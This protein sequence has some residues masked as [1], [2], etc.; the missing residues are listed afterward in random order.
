MHIDFVPKLARDGGPGMT[1]ITDGQ[2]LRAILA[3]CAGNLIEWY[4]FYVYAFTS[5]YFA[6]AFF[7]A[8][9]PLAQVMATSGIFAVGF[10]MRPI[11]AWYFGR[12]ADR[13]G[14]RRAMVLSVLMMGAGALLIAVLPG[15]A[16]VGV[17]APALLLLG[18]MLQGFSTGGQYGTAA[19]YLSE[20][21]S[22]GRRGFWSS[23]QYVTLIGGQLLATLVILALQQALGEAGMKTV[24]WRVAF[25]L[26]A[27]GAGT[28]LL[29]RRYMHETVPDD[30]DGGSLRVLFA[31]ASRPFFIVV[32]LT[33]GGSLAFYTFTTYMQ[34]YLVL[35]V[36][37]TKAGATLLMTGVL[38]LFMLEQPLF[39][40]L[41]DR[42]GRRAN[43]LAFAGLATLLTVPVLN[44]L[45]GA[46]SWVAAF[47]LVLAGLT[48]NALYTSVSGVF[49]AEQFPV[50]VRALGVGLAYGIGNALFGGTAENVALAFK[51]AGHESG[52]YWYV[53]AIAA[54]SFVAA[55]M[56][57]DTGRDSPL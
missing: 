54:V 18:R 43:I 41:S 40:L 33:A 45:A 32:A 56:L 49:K 12:Y 17:A 51:Q 1:T 7:P 2:R 8:S 21:A 37:M 44:L 39:G 48:I 36:G 47:L 3:G 27:V 28:I 5:L 38:L 42:I 29:L 16:R 23:F 9:D 11:G 30:A 19:T 24:G 4:D 57:R 26:G 14:R 53:T 20:V 22:A 46:Q 13:H 25:A 50:H 35:T 52:F 31:E 10:L 15:Y 55:L 6:G 34:K